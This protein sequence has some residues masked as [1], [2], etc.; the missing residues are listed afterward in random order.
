MNET[1]ITQE[2]SNVFLSSLR[3]LL[4]ILIEFGLGYV[5]LALIIAAIVVYRDKIFKGLGNSFDGKIRSEIQEGQIQELKHEL[6]EERKSCDRQIKEMRA[7][8]EDKIT[9]LEAK[10][11]LMNDQILKQAVELAKLQ[12]RLD[13]AQKVAK[14]NYSKSI[15]PS[16]EN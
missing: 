6:E 2:D 8:Y 4:E 7:D 13:A 3:G 14:K 10:M 9:D 15:K 5:L 11:E 12:E 1:N 16:N